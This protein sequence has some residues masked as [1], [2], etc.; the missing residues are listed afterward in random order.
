MGI[1]RPTGEYAGQM[2]EPGGWPEADEDTLYDRAQEY[3]QVLRQV[4]DVMDSTRRQQ[5][6][7]FDGGVWSGGAAN[8]ANG[9]LG[10]NLNQISTL[11]DY[12]ATVITWHRHIAGLL[13]QA[14]SDIGNNVDGAQRQITILENDSELDAEQRQIAINALV[15]ETHAANTSLVAE[16]A[17]QVRASKNWKPPQNALGDLLHQVTPP[18][19]DVPTLAVPSTGSPSPVIPAPT[20]FEPIPANPYDPIEPGPPVTP[21]KPVTPIT[22]VDPAPVTP[23]TPGVPVTPITP[24]NPLPPVT[25]VPPATPGQP[26]TPITPVNPKPD[27][28][29]G[30]QPVTPRPVTPITPVPATPGPSPVPAGPSAPATPTPG[31]HVP[32]APAG[33]TAPGQPDA[34]GDG[35]KPSAPGTEPAHVKPAAATD[36]PPAPGQGAAPSHHKDD[37]SAAVAP[38]AAGGMPAMAGRPVSVSPSAA[39]ASAGSNQ[40]AGSA[41]AS[42]AAS[43][44]TS[45]RAPLGAAGRAPAAAGTRPASARTASPAARPPA[46]QSDKDKTEPADDVTVTPSI[47]VSAARAARDAIAAASRGRGGKSDPL[48]LAR[49]VAAALNAPNSV[50][51]GD[52]GFFWITA[53]TTDGSIVVANSYGLAYVPEGVELPAKVFL[54]SADRAIPPDE[55]ARTATYPVLAVQGWAAFHD[56][57]LR[58]VIGT[59]EQ[60]ANSDPGAAKIILEA[61]DIPDTGNMVGQSR[62]EVVDPSAAAQLADTDDLHLLDLLPPAPADA[63]APD[64]ERHMLWFDLM[65]PMTSTA[66]GRETAHLRAFRAY[67]VHCQEIALHQAYNAA[68]AAAQRPAVA[69]WLYWRYVAGL[70]DSALSDDA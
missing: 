47:P 48:R 53:V 63:D 33:P 18:T 56:L 34:P 3:T 49:R 45:G 30:D 66:V 43:R 42:G 22:P 11:Q 70:L 6:E 50:T 40:G 20:P 68:D 8:A 27:H 51:E 57:K 17:E 55:K 1:P 37:S 62:L 58:A 60:L 2:L 12:L 36:A 52:F 28:P 39:C 35:G 54:A 44:A 16:A 9:A 10:A 23:I 41:A 4:T 32:S 59:A 67:A 69:D 46:D 26:V 13:V 29:A 14:K 25:P 5:V 21:G 19:P 38:A 65:K 24:V 7:V 31:P 15:R 64:D 61:D